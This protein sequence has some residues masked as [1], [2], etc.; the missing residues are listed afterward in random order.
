[1]QRKI[2]VLILW[3]MPTVLRMAAR[4]FPSVREHLGAGNG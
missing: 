2:L 3:L 4:M 1:M